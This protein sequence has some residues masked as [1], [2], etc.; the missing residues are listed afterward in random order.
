MIQ[1]DE[2]AYCADKACD[3]KALRNAL[4]EKGVDDRIAYKAQRNK[5]LAS[6]QKMGQSGIVERAFRG[7]AVQR[8][9]EELVW[10]DA[11]PL[12]RS[13]AQPLS[14]AI[15]GLRDKVEAALVLLGAV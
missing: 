4:A 6:R 15:G 2:E 9:D 1:G 13:G 10:H 7:R 11:G 3:R 8:D 12:S 14:S 5:P